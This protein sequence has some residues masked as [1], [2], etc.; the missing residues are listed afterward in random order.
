MNRWKWRV[1]LPPQEWGPHVRSCREPVLAKRAW[2]STQ[3]PQVVGPQH[4]VVPSCQATGPST[5]SPDSRWYRSLGRAEAQA[6]GRSRTRGN[7]KATAPP[8]AF[9]R[10]L[11]ALPYRA[12][13]E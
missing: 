4:E 2:R 1:K 3:P 7:L 6:D 12:G 11:Y 13:G 10:G 5:G 8:R 9:D